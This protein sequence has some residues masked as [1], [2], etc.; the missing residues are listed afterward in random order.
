MINLSELE[1]RARAASI[2]E[3][4]ADDNIVFCDGESIALDCRHVDAS[5]I[6]SMNPQTALALIRVVRAAIEVSEHHAGKSV[7]ELKEALRKVT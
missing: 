5:F 3:W 6:A 1:Q 4:T 7:D 2:G